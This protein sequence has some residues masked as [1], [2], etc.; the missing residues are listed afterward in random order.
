MTND[1]V[2]FLIPFSPHF[3]DYTFSINIPYL[4]VKDIRIEVRRK[5]GKIGEML[6]LLF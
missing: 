1:H 4:F 2:L 6:L 5:K 3:S